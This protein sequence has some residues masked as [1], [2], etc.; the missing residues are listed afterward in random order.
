M[1]NEVIEF[2]RSEFD[3]K[4]FSSLYYLGIE[5]IQEPG[6]VHMRQTTYIRKLLKK[7]N[8]QDA[9]PVTTPAE[10][11]NNPSRAMKQANFPYREAMQSLMYLAIATRPDI[12]FA[13]S[14]ASRFLDFSDE[15][16]I[17]AVK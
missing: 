3:V 14:H 8:M 12:A 4:V 13:V 7:F 6:K 11:F 17:N 5:I 9:K 1:S 10:I 2:L 15:D 16:N